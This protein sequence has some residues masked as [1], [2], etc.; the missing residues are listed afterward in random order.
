MQP[1]VTPK[2]FFLWLG[3][4]IAIYSSVIAFISLFFEYIDHAFPDALNYYVDPY[5]GGIRF[6]MATLIVMVPVALILMR[7]IRKDIQSVPQKSDLWVRRWALVLTVFIAGLSV[8]GDLI[9]LINYFLGG[10]LTMRFVLKVAIVLLVASAVFMHFI[11]DLWGYWTIYPARARSVGWAAGVAVLLIIVAGFFIMGSPN[12]VR[13]IR[14]DNQKIS[15]LQNVQ[16]QIVNFWQQKERLPDPLTELKDPLSGWTFPI[17]PQIGYA[18]RY[19]KTGP[20]SFKLCATFNT[21]GSGVE[22]GARTIPVA[23]PESVGKGLE[24]TWQHGIGETCFDRRIDPERYPPYP[25][26]VKAMQ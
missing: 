1:K 4:V 2:D 8:V 9:M 11:A 23:Y 6:A 20:M 15:D 7:V 10:D 14:F 26:D 24:D 16:W 22:R 5:S 12:Q 13:L 19:K 21:E 17:D 25:K 18:Y 3:A